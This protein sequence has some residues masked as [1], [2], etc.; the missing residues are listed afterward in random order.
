LPMQP[1]ILT[2]TSH[3]SQKAFSTL[4]KSAS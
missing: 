4:R 2:E 3:K 1:A